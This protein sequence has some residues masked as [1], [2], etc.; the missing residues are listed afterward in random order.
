MLK[1]C[2][3]ITFNFSSANVSPSSLIL[4]NNIIKREK[5]IELLGVIISDDLKWK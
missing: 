5:S 1:K 4:D 3:T 2:H